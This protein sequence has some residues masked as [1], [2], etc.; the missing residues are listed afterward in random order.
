MRKKFRL[1]P[2]LLAVL[3]VLAA[4]LGSLIVF[5]KLLTAGR[6]SFHTMSSMVKASIRTTLQ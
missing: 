5:A 4:V 2:V 3:A 6:I 1:I